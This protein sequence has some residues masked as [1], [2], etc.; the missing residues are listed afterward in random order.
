MGVEA[1]EQRVKAGERQAL[2]KSELRNR[3]EPWYSMVLRVMLSHTGQHPIYCRP[4]IRNP[5]VTED[6]RSGH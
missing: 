2:V 5:I 1:R 4:D 6:R 3:E